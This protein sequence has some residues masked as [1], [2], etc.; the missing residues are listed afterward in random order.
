MR[1][2][3]MT[4]AYDGTNYAGWQIQAGPITIQQ[5]LEEALQKI[6]GTPIRIV[7]SGRTDAGVHAFGQVVS[8]A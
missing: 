8:F 7:A 4:L 5:T 2:F 3:K 1:P 6:T